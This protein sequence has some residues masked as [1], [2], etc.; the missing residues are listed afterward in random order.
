MRLA[1]S[2]LAHDRTRFAVTVLGITAAVFL[3]VF[4]ASI[5]L[6]FLR[7]SSKVIDSTSADLWLAGRGVTCF[8]FPVEIERRFV[9]IARS[10]PGVAYTSRICTRVVQFQKPD[11]DH[12][13]VSLIGADPGVGS[14]FPR[15]R[16]SAAGGVA[17]P[18]SLLVDE[19]N[20]RLL[21]VSEKPTDVEVNQL[22]ARVVGEITGFG[23]FLGSPYVFTSYRDAARYI[24]LRP[25][26]TMFILAHIQ[27]D[28]NVDSVKAALRTRLPNL[29]VWSR[30]EFSQRA[31]TYWIT[32]TGAGGAILTAAV[33]GFLIGLT[34]V[35][36]AIYATTMENI[37][38]FATL[39]ALG[40]T[41]GFIRRV[42]ISQS[43]ICGTF[44]YIAGILLTIP[45]IRLTA[46]TI[47]WVASP[48]WINAGVLLPAVA[49]CVLASLMSVRTALS[50]EPAKVFRA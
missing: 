32:Q 41:N 45:M 15:P 4:Q 43:L 12:Q 47:P 22:R 44:G 36:Q 28:A 40:A 10:A 8:E 48:W 38:E 50:V 34:I 30:E 17:E 14:T 18:D 23:S 35:S 3:M 13:L 24:Q 33:L 37:E 21:Q 31:R 6:G 11:G 16:L 2:N 42:I 39:K 26:Y 46:S 19:S 29:D 9:E 5:L 27:P 1:W 25:E 20:A 7:A 49:M